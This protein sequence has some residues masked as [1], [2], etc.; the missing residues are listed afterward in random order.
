MRAQFSQTINDLKVSVKE[1]TFEETHVA[2]GWAD[3][4]VVGEYAYMLVLSFTRRL[5]FL[6]S[7]GFPLVSGLRQ[8][9]G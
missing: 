2:D 3:L 1:G 5:D 4:I 8:G 6:C 9:H 7:T